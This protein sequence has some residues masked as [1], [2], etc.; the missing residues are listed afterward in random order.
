MGSNRSII[1]IIVTTY[2]RPDYLQQTIG[3]ILE[4]TRS[5][6]A[7]HVIDDGSDDGETH[8]YL[9]NLREQGKLASLVTRIA[10]AGMMANRN[11]AAWLAFSDPFV[12]TDDDVLCP[13]I[14]PD[15]LA[16]ATAAMLARPKLAVMAL[17]HPGAYRI[18]YDQDDEV[19]YCEAVGCTFQFVR[20][21]LAEAW[22]V[23]HYRNNWGVTDDV[24]RC[25]AARERGWLVGYMRAVYCYHIGVKSML[26][27]GRDYGGKFIPVV[28]W[29][30]L[31][32]V[33]AEHVNYRP[34]PNA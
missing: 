4:R 19:V 10:R 16:R 9:E 6:Y 20:R 32:P 22:H 8:D 7:L 28:S 26:T 29:G 2:N 21:Y 11:V 14:D 33:D 30:T 25:C 34:V 31:E 12:L 1:D 17:N 23:A 18:P 24:Q 3:H 5:P 27:P 15:W 13:D